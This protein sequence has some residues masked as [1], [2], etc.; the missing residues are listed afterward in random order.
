MTFCRRRESSNLMPTLGKCSRLL[1]PSEPRMVTTTFLH[2]ITASLSS[3][4]SSTYVIRVLVIGIN[5]PI[6]SAGEEANGGRHPRRAPGEQKKK[7]SRP[8]PVAEEK[9]EDDSEYRYI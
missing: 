6:V 7:K 5:S 3:L 4:S 1:A 2:H 9:E 8:K